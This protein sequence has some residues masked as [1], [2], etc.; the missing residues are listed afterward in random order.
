[1]GTSCTIVLSLEQNPES[2]GQESAKVPAFRL[3]FPDLS[4]SGGIW[5]QSRESCWKPSIHLCLGPIYP[6]SGYRGLVFIMECLDQVL[7]HFP[8]SLCPPVHPL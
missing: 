1:M 4:E 6:Q 3:C 2:V 7:S 8:S 5:G